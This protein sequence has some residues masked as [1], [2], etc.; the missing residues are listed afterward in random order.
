[1][2][3]WKM[4]PKAKVYEALSAVADGRVKMMDGNT[5]EVASSS[6]TKTYT[7]QWNEDAT[8]MVSDDNGTHWEEYIGYPMIA[9]LM[10]L[11]KISCSPD[12]TGMFANIRWKQLKDAF[13]HNYDKAADV[14]LSD[15][16][17]KG[18]QRADI[19]LEIDTIYEQLQKLN[20]QKLE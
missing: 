12:K 5:A 10:V 19:E 2:P 15:L 3:Y 8:C 9:V 11:G 6:H 18:N 7:V 16:E 13:H 20:L 14:V 4:P 17:A 1:M